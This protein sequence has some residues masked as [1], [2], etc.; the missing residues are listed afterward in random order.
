MVS[1]LQRC[2]S[3][4]GTETFPACNISYL[5]KQ[6]KRLRLHSPKN[7]T[8]TFFNCKIKKMKISIPRR[9]ERRDGTTGIKVLI[10][11]QEWRSEKYLHYESIWRKKGKETPLSSPVKIKPP[12]TREVGQMK[13]W[14]GE[15]SGFIISCD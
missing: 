3:P 7:P 5:K 11:R 1:G 15:Q 8:T 13:L 14:G 10:K 4:G 12:K 6:K 9:K 2:E